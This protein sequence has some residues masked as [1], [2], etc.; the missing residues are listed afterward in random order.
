MRLGPEE[1]REVVETN[2]KQRFAFSE[3]AVRIRASQGHSVAVELG[4]RESSPPATRFRGTVPKFLDSIRG[5]GL[6]A[7]TRHHLHL[8]GDLET[9]RAVG[10]RRGKPVV[11]MVRAGAMEPAGHQFFRSENGV[12]LVEHVPPG[13]LDSEPA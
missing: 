1:L 5:E 6:I 13:F 8:S 11:L 10:G 3:D 7:G 4:Y 9:A 2:D 12:W